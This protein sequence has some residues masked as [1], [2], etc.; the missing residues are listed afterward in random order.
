MSKILLLAAVLFTAI[1][2]YMVCSILQTTA[3]IDW[4]QIVR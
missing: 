4:T 3:M 2:L 1:T